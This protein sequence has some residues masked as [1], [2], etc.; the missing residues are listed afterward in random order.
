[1]A[2]NAESGPKRGL[3]AA[4]FFV[5]PYVAASTLL[6]VSYAQVFGASRRF[7]AEPPIPS[8]ST[9]LDDRAANNTYDPYTG[10]L[11]PITV[12]HAT[13]TMLAR[14]ISDIS[15]VVEQHQMAMRGD[16]LAAAATAYSSMLKVSQAVADITS[17]FANSGEVITFPREPLREIPEIVYDPDSHLGD[18]V[19]TLPV[20]FKR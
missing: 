3:S 16:Y 9:G 15:W 14:H 17:A 11:N 12:F 7:S 19:R 1:M 4:D 20:A 2:E 8:D 13:G 18:N 10:L 5:G 6:V